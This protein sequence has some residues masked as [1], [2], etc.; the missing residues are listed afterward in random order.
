MID[1]TC[2]PLRYLSHS[3]S[4]F[5]F[6]S[7]LNSTSIYLVQRASAVPIHLLLISSK[8]PA[9]SSAASVR[10][11]RRC[12]LPATA[13]ACPSQRKH[14]RRRRLYVCQRGCKGRQRGCHARDQGPRGVRRGGAV[15][16]TTCT[17]TCTCIPFIFIFIFRIVLL[18][19]NWT[20]CA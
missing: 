4:L 19:D 7:I 13:P 6:L 14:A 15:R 11:R 9:T 8:G 20:G 1:S 12:Q 18:A 16:R 10:R 2:T 5:T 3:G 17:C